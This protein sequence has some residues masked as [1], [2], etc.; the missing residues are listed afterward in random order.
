MGVFY[1]VR[2]LLGF[3]PFCEKY[4]LTPGIQGKT[5][6]IQGLG[7]VGYWT[8]KFCQDGGA[9]I[10][11]IVEYNSSISNP[12]GL[13]V[14]EASK[15]FRANKSFKDYPKAK[16]VYLDDK[17]MDA[18]YLECDILIPAAIENTLTK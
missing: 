14:E 13:D 8:A 2:E 17:I 7:N 11:A 12:D 9:K 3:P 6:V 18:M 1:G 15:Y 5:V 16:V 4:H 10:I